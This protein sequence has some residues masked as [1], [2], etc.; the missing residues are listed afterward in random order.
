MNDE[1]AQDKSKQNLFFVG[2]H[3]DSQIGWMGAFPD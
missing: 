3:Q 2:N 1:E